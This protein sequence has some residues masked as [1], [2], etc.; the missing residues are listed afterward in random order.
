[1]TTINIFHVPNTVLGPKIKQLKKQLLALGELPLLVFPSVIA[2]SS[3]CPLHTFYH[4][5]SALPAL[6]TPLCNLSNTMAGHAHAMV[7]VAACFL[8][9]G[10][11]RE[12]DGG[13]AEN[14]VQKALRK[15]GPLVLEDPARL[16]QSTLWVAGPACL[17]H[18]IS[19]EPTPPGSQRLLDKPE[20]YVKKKNEKAPPK[21]LPKQKSKEQQQQNKQR[22]Q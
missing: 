5:P 3:P 17:S 21:Q 8:V 16:R 7:S 1:M 11:T 20:G 15:A 19:F 10:D 2:S 18:P 4:H 9:R 13:G 12:W 22:L 6:R 14:W